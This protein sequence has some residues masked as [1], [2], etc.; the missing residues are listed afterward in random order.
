MGTKSDPRESQETQ[1]DT[2]GDRRDPKGGQRI[3]NYSKKGSKMVP[4]WSQKG[5]K[6]ESKSGPRTGGPYFQDFE[7]RLEPFES[8]RNLS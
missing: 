2:K 8:W 3:E 4:K 5:A 7:R 1:R 6:K